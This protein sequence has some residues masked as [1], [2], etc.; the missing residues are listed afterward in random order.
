MARE[1]AT[2]ARIQM[3][4]TRTHMGARVCACACACGGGRR[5]H[6]CDTVARGD[7]RLHLDVHADGRRA[8]DEGCA[9]GG[10]GRDAAQRQQREHGVDQVDQ[11]G[12]EGAP[13]IVEAEDGVGE[14]DALGGI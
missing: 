4:A 6:L 2:S 10:G 11:L 5:R 9:E 1:A 8:G 12:A 14:R 13:P 3:C 7:A